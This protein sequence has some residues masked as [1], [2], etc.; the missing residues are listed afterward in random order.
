[1]SRIQILDEG[2]FLINWCKFPPLR[3]RPVKLGEKMIRVYFNPRRL[4]CRGHCIFFQYD[5]L[6]RVII[7]KKAQVMTKAIKTP[8]TPRLKQFY[9]PHLTMLLSL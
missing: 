4:L 6:F 3:T 5:L 8:S 2:D 9:W 7:L 1:M